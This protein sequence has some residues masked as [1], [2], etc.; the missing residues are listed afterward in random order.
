MKFIRNISDTKKQISQNIFWALLAKVVSMSSS[1]LVG[2]LVARYL[3]PQQYGL[4]NYVVS[5]VSIFTILATFGLDN[6]EIR[7]LSKNID[8]RNE[9]LG[10][11]FIARSVFSV[12]S[13]LIV[14]SISLICESDSQTIILLAIYSLSLALTP[15]DAIRNYFTSIVKNEYVSKVSIY[16]V[17]L[18]SILKIVLLLVKAPLIFFVVSLVIDALFGAQGYLSSYKHKIGK[19]KEWKFN[20][21]IAKYLIPEAFPLLLSG[22]AA[23]IF[24]RID[25]VMIGNMLDKESVGYF[26]VASKF[27]EI[28]IF[29][30][31]ILISTITP[32]LIRL[33]KSDTVLYYQRAQVFLNITV[34]L[35]VCMSVA[36][37]FLS[38]IIIKWTF[39]PQYLAAIPI[40]QILSFKV[41]PVSL[42]VISGQILII[43]GKQDLFVLRSLSGCICCV[44]FNYIFIPKFGLS[45]VAYIA[46]L[47]QVIAGFIIH[48]FIPKYRYVFNMQI[49]SIFLG[50]KDL[51]KLPL[52]IKS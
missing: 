48:I 49:K 20:I 24:L 18:S 46:I 13:I 41:I 51:F 44:L 42:N 23:Y 8:S 37:C 31:S 1:L 30:P 14:N 28:L 10:T 29:I 32:L 2:I 19:I 47:T 15:F 36:F 3:G 9:I 34:W 33:K 38:P 43:D 7:E 21:D 27:V 25:Q 16:R 22:A 39:G 52:L 17:I 35:S 26:S 5:F 40:L 6:I 4:M 45:S 50:W 11:T 12:A